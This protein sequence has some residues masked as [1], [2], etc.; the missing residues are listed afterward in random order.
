VF[1]ATPHAL[2]RDLESVLERDMLANFLMTFD[3]SNQVLTLD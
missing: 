3:Q 1:I 2:N